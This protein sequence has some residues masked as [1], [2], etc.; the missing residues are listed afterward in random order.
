MSV[1]NKPKFGDK[2]HIEGERAIVLTYL[3]FCDECV[4]A[5]EN[6]G[7]IRVVSIDEFD[8]Y[9]PDPEKQLRERI[10]KRWKNRNIDYALDTEDG[11]VSIL[12]GDIIDFVL[13]NIKK[14]EERG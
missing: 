9:R 7:I 4:V 10:L 11:T 8:G 12:V 6:G 14:E 2:L 5:I 3:D 1:E 13:E